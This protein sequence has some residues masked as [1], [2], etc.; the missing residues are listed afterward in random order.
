MDAINVSLPDWVEIITWNDFIEGTYVSPIDD[1]NKYQYANFLVTTGVPTST[2][3][4]FHSHYGATDLLP[5]FI[6]WYKTGTQPPI[7]R[8]A[9]YY[10]YRTQQASY[11]AGTPPV[12]N[13]YGPVA[14][15]IYIT[16]NLTAP[17]T[18]KVNSGGQST[19]INLPAGSTDT[20][21]P[22]VPGDTHVLRVGP[23]RIDG[24]ERIGDRPDPNRGPVQRLLLLDRRPGGLR[25][26][27]E[28]PSPRR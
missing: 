8:D 3:G 13:K 2:L 19:L 15:V 18:L 10:A 22:F 21:T 17:A 9:I 14:D 23:E 4:Y 5:F 20:Q 6:H 26:L 27:P 16:S 24:V 11:D 12:A 25:R 7:T 1:P 28:P